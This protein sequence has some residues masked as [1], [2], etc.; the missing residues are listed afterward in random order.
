MATLAKRI[1]VSESTPIIRY[2]H[3]SEDI[4]RMRLTLGDRPVNRM[5]ES[6]W[7]DLQ[8]FPKTGANLA[9]LREKLENASEDGTLPNAFA[10]AM[11]V[12]R[13][14]HTRRMELAEMLQPMLD[15]AV[16][17]DSSHERY[18]VPPIMRAVRNDYGGFTLM[19][20]YEDRKPEDMVVRF[21]SIRGDVR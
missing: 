19:L 10:I 13:A 17:A 20:A 7:S 2:P 6:L 18:L 15:L 16:P 11:Q 14:A 12:A 8:A 3:V 4:S 21:S 9:E 5:T 1:Q